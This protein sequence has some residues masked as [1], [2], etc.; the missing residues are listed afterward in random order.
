MLARAIASSLREADIEPILVYEPHGAA[1][2]LRRFLRDY[3]GRGEALMVSGASLVV[4]ALMA[5]LSSSI[6]DLTPWRG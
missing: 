4:R 2:G 1:S 6:D 3:A 5:R